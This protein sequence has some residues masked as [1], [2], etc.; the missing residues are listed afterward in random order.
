M[1]CI[2]AYDYEYTAVKCQRKKNGTELGEWRTEYEQK[3]W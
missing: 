3:V 1:L 2:D